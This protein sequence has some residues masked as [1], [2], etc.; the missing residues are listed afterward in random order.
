M[1][2]PPKNAGIVKGR[3]VSY[4]PISTK[5]LYTG[6]RRSMLGIIIVPKPTVKMIFLPTN[7]IFT[8]AYAAINA[9]KGTPTILHATISKVFLSPLKKPVFENTSLYVPIRLNSLGKS[10]ASVEVI[11]AVV[12][13]L[14]VIRINTGKINIIVGRIYAR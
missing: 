12:K 10:P 14:L 13:K 4:H 1:I 6:R 2:P 3:S 8:N 7:G 9:V 11:S 5:I